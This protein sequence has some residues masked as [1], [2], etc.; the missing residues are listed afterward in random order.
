MPLHQVR[1][2]RRVHTDGD[3]GLTHGQIQLA[4]I[5]QQ[6][7]RDV[8]IFLE[9]IVQARREP[10]RTKPH[11]RRHLQAP[12]GLFLALRQQRLGHR[13]LREHLVEALALL[14]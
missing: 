3:V 7:H 6:R 8:R 12:G 4:V 11:R 9:K 1:L 14:G 10:V 2:L 13:Q 5:E